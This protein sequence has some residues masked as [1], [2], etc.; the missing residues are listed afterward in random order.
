[1]KCEHCGK[2]EATFYYKSNINGEVTEQHLCSDCAKELGYAD[3][4]AKSTACFRNWEQQMFGG[5]DGFF[6][7]MPALAGNLFEPFEQM[8]NGFERSFPQL[9]GW[10]SGMPEQSTAPCVQ[11]APAAPG[12]DLVSGEEQQ[13]LDRERRLNALRGEMQTA[14]QKENF[15]RAAELR[16]EIHGLERQ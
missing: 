8:V 7:P 11:N 5:F 12:S 16:D 13:K 2:N 9:G 6:D 10:M 15:E 4:L 3:S 14:I 1:M